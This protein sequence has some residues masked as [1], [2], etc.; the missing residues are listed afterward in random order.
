MY[1]DGFNKRFPSGLP[2]SLLT[3]AKKF[4][5]LASSSNVINVTLLS[6]FGKD[7]ELSLFHSK[8]IYK[9]VVVET[10]G[11]Y[12]LSEKD[13]FLVSPPT[14]QEKIV[15]SRRNIKIRRKIQRRERRRWVA[16]NF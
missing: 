4:E 8:D 15:V 10:S 6:N 13:S 7:V 11:E 12:I 14:V 16:A 3:A 9:G 1:S 2:A 5:D